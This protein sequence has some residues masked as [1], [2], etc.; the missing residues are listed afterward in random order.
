[1]ANAE[2]SYKNLSYTTSQLSLFNQEIE[3]LHEER[4]ALQDIQ[5]EFKHEITQTRHAT[6]TMKKSQER[7]ANEAVK[8]YKAAQKQDADRGL[9]QKEMTSLQADVRE[10][11]LDVA[12]VQA[13]AQRLR[14]VLEEEVKAVQRL[15]KVTAKMK[16]ETQMQTKVRES[17]RTEAKLTAKQ[18]EQ[19]EGKIKRLSE[20]NKQFMKRIN[21]TVFQDTS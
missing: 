2:Q 14:E 3:T 1:M 20:A 15:E 7:L 19:M 11:E 8:L 5:A 12:D 4:K 9:M 13:E 21:S 6:Q 16:K 18:T 17:L 10:L